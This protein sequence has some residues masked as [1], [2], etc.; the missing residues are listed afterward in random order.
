MT[1]RRMRPV[2]FVDPLPQA[3]AE[4]LGVGEEVAGA[5]RPVEEEAR[6]LARVRVEMKVVVSLDAV[7]PAEDR[8]VWPPARA[9]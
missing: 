4:D 8:V 3:I 2:S 6:D 1:T 7:G 9:G 5:S